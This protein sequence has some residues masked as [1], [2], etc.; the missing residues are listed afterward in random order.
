LRAALRGRGRRPDHLAARQ[1]ARRERARVV[2]QH[3]EPAEHDDC[4][5]EIHQDRDCIERERR[6]GRMIFEAETILRAVHDRSSSPCFCTVAT[7]RPRTG[8]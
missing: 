1:E 5:D 7:W 2:D 8:L 6:V 4:R 3:D